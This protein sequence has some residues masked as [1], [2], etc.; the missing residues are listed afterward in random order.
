MA[1][2][3]PPRTLIPLR[4][5]SLI[6]YLLRLSY[7]LELSPLELGQVLGL[8]TV[9]S[10]L[11][12]RLMLEIEPE[13]ATRFA[14]RAGLT[15]AEVDSLTYRPDADVY[16][17]VNRHAHPNR[18]SWLPQV[19]GYEPWLL[20]HSTRYCPQ[21]LAGDGST[22][23]TR[24]GGAWSKYWRFAPVFAC[25]THERLLNHLCPVCAQPA[26]TRNPI[27]YNQL[28]PTPASL[29]MH[30]ATC[31]AP[32]EGGAPCPGRFDD[33]NQMEPIIAD[34]SILPKLLAL[35]KRLVSRLET[36]NA[37]KNIA[38]SC[39]Q[40]VTAAQ[41]FADLQATSTILATILLNPAITDPATRFASG[42]AGIYAEL[43]VFSADTNRGE[44]DPHFGTFSH[45]S[46]GTQTAIPLESAASGCLLALAESLLHAKTPSAV[47]DRL[48]VL[49]DNA[50]VRRW[51][52][53]LR[54]WSNLGTFTS[55]GMKAAITSACRGPHAPKATNA[56]PAK[57]WR[58]LRESLT[59]GITE[60]PR[61]DINRIPQRLPE[62][63]WTQ[64]FD[65]RDGETA[66]ARRRLAIVTLTALAEKCPLS[67]ALLRLDLGRQGFSL[68]A[69]ENGATL[70][71]DDL[72]RF[73]ASVSALI[74]DLN[75]R[76]VLTD[77]GRRRNAMRDW[78]LDG[79]V[80][81][82][83]TSSMKGSALPQTTWGENKQLLCAIYIWCRVTEGEHL[84]AP[85]LA[86]PFTSTAGHDPKR[87]YVRMTWREFA[88]ARPHSYLHELMNRMNGHAE[89]LI[90]AIDAGQRMTA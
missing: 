61:F 13:R 44:R 88:R 57:R 12:G 5:E 87:Q 60:V 10:R 63:W 51:T 49:L 64:H 70:G 20:S 86:R 79:P 68:D 6:G 58:S 19:I 25:L 48:Q 11:P 15:L 41:Y 23:Q 18:K 56:L 62:V 27:Y 1:L 84:R 55:D 37:R 26:L 24:F 47:A 30:P 38:H 17:P 34:R 50:D 89:E 35:Q 66:L 3:T 31:R 45:A 16:P 54:R 67:D 69:L 75:S 14:D 39:G 43:Q 80:W 52:Y 9:N 2:R 22:I 21:C 77:Y 73:R 53:N 40:P 71:A 81:H 74:H 33:P 65:N 76:A 29:D 32:T 7:R 82:N 4:N 85:I 72:M 78:T 28:I 36:N 59:A 90:A 42:L 83:L 46:F 8:S